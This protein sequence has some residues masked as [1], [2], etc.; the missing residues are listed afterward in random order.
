[1]LVS[2][3]VDDVEFEAHV[4]HLMQPIEQVGELTI[5]VVASECAEDYYSNHDGWEAKWPIELEVLSRAD[6]SVL[7]RFSVSM[8]IEPHFYSIRIGTVDTGKAERV[9]L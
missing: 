6:G 7:G 5:E 8:E 9:E 1:M 2:Y 3:R 4:R